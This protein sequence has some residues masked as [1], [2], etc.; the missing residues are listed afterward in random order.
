M[1]AP[2]AAAEDQVVFRLQS[3]TTVV[4]SAKG[5]EPR[6]IEDSES[7]PVLRRAAAPIVG[8]GSLVLAN[9][10][11]VRCVDSLTFDSVWELELP[12]PVQ[13]LTLDGDEILAATKETIFCLGAVE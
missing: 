13:E 7:G 5:E 10:K 6:R 12:A 8:L 2:V 3:G 11:M 1:V 9:G 4:L